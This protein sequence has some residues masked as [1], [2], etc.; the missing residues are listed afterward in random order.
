MLI[1]NNLQVRTKN[2]KL[3]ILLGQK[4]L[5][6]LILSMVCISAFGFGGKKKD[7]SS[8]I[9]SIQTE[10]GPVNISFDYSLRTSDQKIAKLKD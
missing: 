5:L 4:K 10:N 9:I 6:I 3:A 8:E 2:I 7:L 1:K